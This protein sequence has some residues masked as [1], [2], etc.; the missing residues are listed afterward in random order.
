MKLGIGESVQTRRLLQTTNSRESSCLATRIMRVK[1][2]RTKQY[3][4]YGV[5]SLYETGSTGFVQT[6]SG[7]NHKL[8]KGP[9]PPVFLRIIP[10]SLGQTLTLTPSSTLFT[11]QHYVRNE[12]HLHSAG[13][14]SMTCGLATPIRRIQRALWEQVCVSPRL[15]S[16]A[17]WLGGV[18]RLWR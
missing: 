12:V 6:W 5:L 17:T 2:I 7:A 16:F 10:H 1:V 18:G 9:V 3:V 14:S 15:A 8:C 13:S 11:Q 4:N